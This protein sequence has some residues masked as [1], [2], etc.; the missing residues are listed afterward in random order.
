MYIVHLSLIPG[1]ETILGPMLWFFKYFRRKIRPKNL[2][3][4]FVLFL[5][6]TKLNFAKFWSLHWFLRKAPFF[7][8]KLSKIAENCDHN[9]DPCTASMS[10]PPITDPIFY[11][12]TSLCKLPNPDK[13]KLTKTFG[14][15][16]AELVLLRR[17]LFEK[18]RWNST[19]VLRN[20]VI[21]KTKLFSIFTYILLQPKT[22]L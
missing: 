17:A 22:T 21:F 18:D 8:W 10:R 7:R 14:H 12:K 11:L 15:I 1:T 4:K 5:L 13:A 20:P 3:K 2:A 19:I 16:L 9:I 6:K